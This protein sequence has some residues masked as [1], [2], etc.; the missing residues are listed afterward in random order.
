MPYRRVRNPC[1][2]REEHVA[3]AFSS[4]EWMVHLLLPQELTQAGWDAWDQTQLMAKYSGTR[5]AS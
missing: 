4:T 3:L 1:S 2:A 5:N